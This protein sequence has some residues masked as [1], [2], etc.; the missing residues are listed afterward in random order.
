MVKSAV[1]L[2]ERRKVKKGEKERE[3]VVEGEE[4]VEREKVGWEGRKPTGSRRC[5]CFELLP[6]SFHLL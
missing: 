2:R 5:C 4:E 3:R 6:R 1:H